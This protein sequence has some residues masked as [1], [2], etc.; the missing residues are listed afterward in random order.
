MRIAE[1]ER[2]DA[3]SRPYPCVVA[4]V[5]T[6]SD[7]VWLVMAVGTT[8]PGEDLAERRTGHDPNG[9]IQFENDGARNRYIEDGDWEDGI[10][11]GSDEEGRKTQA[12]HL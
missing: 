10:L 8:H 9:R 6:C 11:H 12:H 4:G 5:L 2:R 7:V 1:S 3:Y